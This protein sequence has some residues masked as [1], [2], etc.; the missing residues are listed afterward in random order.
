MDFSSLIPKPQDILNGV[1]A[2]A[3]TPSTAP[4][5]GSTPDNSSPLSGALAGAMKAA[6]NALNPTSILFGGLTLQRVVFIILGLLLIAAGIFAFKPV[7]ETVVTTAKEGA[8]AA[9]IAA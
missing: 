1:G 7:R 6:T 4:A 3:P 5:S 2:S 9:A 8:K